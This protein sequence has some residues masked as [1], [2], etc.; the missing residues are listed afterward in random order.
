MSREAVRD[1]E[2]LRVWPST[3]L[4]GYLFRKDPDREARD[5]AA[6]DL[7]AWLANLDRWQITQAQV[8]VPASAPD[9]AFEQLAGH[10]GR[11][12]LAGR[13]DP[14][15]GMAGIRPPRR[16]AGGDSRRPHAAL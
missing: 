15:E 14:H 1:R 11:A 9:E 8:P 2:S 16:L 12:F 4:A 13:L 3:D 5:A 7:D 10:S 6:R